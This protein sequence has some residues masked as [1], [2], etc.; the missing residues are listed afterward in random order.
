MN[1]IELINRYIN[2]I[3][4]IKRNSEGIVYRNF[5]FEPPEKFND[6]NSQEWIKVYTNGIIERCDLSSI[7]GLLRSERWLKSLH[8]SLHNKN[9]FIFAASLRGLIESSADSF[10]L[11]HVLLDRLFDFFPYF[12]MIQN[13]YKNIDFYISFDDIE[14]KLIHFS[15]AKKQKDKNE[16]LPDHDPKTNKEYISYIETFLKLERLTE[17]YYELCNLTHPASPSVFCF[18]DEYNDKYILN[19]SKESELIYQMLKKYEKTIFNLIAGSVDYLLMALVILDKLYKNSK[20][21]GNLTTLKNE[22]FLNEISKIDS[23]ISE[24]NCGKFDASNFIQDLKVKGYKI[25]L[26]TE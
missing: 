10:F 15:F 8:E 12:Y 4:K 11:L 2:Y 14:K 3:E 16:I 24:Y 1:L 26:F 17:L 6:N 7:T 19:I 18:I 13:D 21:I 5:F 25:T 20:V 9:L 22:R 23:F